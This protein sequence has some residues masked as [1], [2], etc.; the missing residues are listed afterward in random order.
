MIL[1]IRG[2]IFYCQFWHAFRF[3]ICT[4]LNDFHLSI[5]WEFEFLFAVD[6]NSGSVPN[7]T[8]NEG[9]NVPFEDWLA[10][11]WLSDDF[12]LLPSEYFD[13]GQ[14]VSSRSAVPLLASSWLFEN[15]L[16]FFSA[17]YFDDL[18]WV[19]AHSVFPLYIARTD[20]SLLALN[21]WMAD[22]PCKCPLSI[23]ICQLIWKLTPFRSAEYFDDW[24]SVS[25]L[26]C[27]IFFCK[28]WLQFCFSRIFGTALRKWPLSCPFCS[29]FLAWKL[30]SFSFGCMFRRY[31]GR[32]CLLS[33]PFCLYSTVWKLTYLLAE[34]FDDWQTVSAL[35][36]VLFADT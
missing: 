19:S 1:I 33:G 20:F 22:Q 2:F 26:S 9:R 34:C 3:L 25:L 17:D 10:L 28:D 5:S 30:I 32:K 12:H 15:G 13:D 14:L 23:Q 4:L 31:K 8:M 21:F 7:L 35:S 27:P 16:L 6:Y 29:P 18:Q 11:W 36:A 24:Q